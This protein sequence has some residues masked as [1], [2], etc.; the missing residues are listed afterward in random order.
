[1]R[2]SVISSSGQVLASG[3]LFLQTDEAGDLQLGFRSDRG[4]IIEGGKIDAD[5]SLTNASKE[6]F[7]GFFQAWGISGVTLTVTG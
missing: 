7:R 6:L 4:R 3:H 1:M 5:G 2:C